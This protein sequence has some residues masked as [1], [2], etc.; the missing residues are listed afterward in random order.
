MRRVTR[1]PAS[2]I[3]A[4]GGWDKEACNKVEAFDYI[5]GDWLPSH[6]QMPIQIAYHNIQM[7][8][9]KIYFVGG[10]SPELGYQSKRLFFKLVNILY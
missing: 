7:I 9:D 2:I 4:T 10:F 3:I 8:Q 1:K 6:F 5:S